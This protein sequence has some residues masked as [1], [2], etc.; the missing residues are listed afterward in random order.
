MLGNKAKS[1]RLGLSFIGWAI[2][3]IFTFGIGLLWLIPYMNV[4]VAKF[5]DDI[6]EKDIGA[7]LG[8]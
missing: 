3:S 2:L 6:K 5:Y 8:L 7:G 4:S 1:F